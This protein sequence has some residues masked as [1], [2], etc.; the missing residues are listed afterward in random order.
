MKWIYYFLLCTTGILSAYETYDEEYSEVAYDA[1]LFRKHEQVY[2]GH[3]SFLYWR[4]QEGALDYALKMQ[5][6]S[7]PG[8]V[9]A[10]G[11][12][13]RATFDG[14]PGFRLALGYFR[15][16]RLW[17]LWFQYTRMTASGCDSVHAPDGGNRFL[18]GTWPQVTEGPISEAKSR[19]HLNYNVGDFL[20]DRFCNPNPHLRARFIGGGTV[21]WINQ[22]WIVRYFDADSVVTQIQNRWKYIGGGLRIGTMIDWF[23]GYDIYMTGGTTIAYYLGSYHNIARQTASTTDL[24]IRN[25]HYFDVRPVFSAQATFGLSWQ[26]NFCASR[27]EIFGGYEINTWFNLVEIYRS[28][29]GD[30]LAAKE[31]LM[32][33]GL[34]ALQ[35][36]TA[37]LSA[38]F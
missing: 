5:Q 17:E 19:I 21:A 6:A 13:H 33:S 8:T 12:Y 36:L 20:V 30:A 18:T 35:G 29:A 15:A 1:D 38:D 37:R 31:T 32:N 25:T 24:Y 11:E 34:L 4:A 23:C 10:Q 14:E 26:K 2:S 7:P 16:L 3:V 27:I 28:T 9:Y 22:N